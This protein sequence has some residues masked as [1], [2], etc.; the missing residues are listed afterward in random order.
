MWAPS[1]EVYQFTNGEPLYGEEEVAQKKKRVPQKCSIGDQQKAKEETLRHPIETIRDLKGMV[2]DSMFA[3]HLEDLAD[4][5]LEYFK[6]PI[7][8]EQLAELGYEVIPCL[9]EDKK[10]EAFL[11]CYLSLRLTRTTTPQA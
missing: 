5:I 2:Y 9:Q 6:W 7:K 10:L 1:E 8:D 11:K 4:K 3:M